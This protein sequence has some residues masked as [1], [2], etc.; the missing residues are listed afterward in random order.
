[1]HYAIAAELAKKH[2]V[3]G[4]FFLG[5]EAPDTNKESNT[6]KELT[7]FMTLDA[8]QEHVMHI[9]NFTQKYHAASNDDFVIGYYAH[10]VADDIWL[11][12]MFHKYIPSAG[13]PDRN[14]L[15]ALYYADF[16]RL[17]QLIIEHYQLTFNSNLVAKPKHIIDE[18]QYQDLPMVWREVQMD[19]EEIP[20]A[21]DL[22]LFKLADVF[23]YIDAT[24]KILSVAMQHDYAF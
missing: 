21:G 17:N 16:A 10:L 13:E 20:E 19:F 6:P 4:A 24:V 3:N 12:T 14:R 5:N 9:E 23:E 22:Q 1:M 11:K 8:N 15:L 18:I 7:H 2:P